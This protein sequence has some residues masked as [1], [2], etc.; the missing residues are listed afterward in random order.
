MKVR[1]RQ[2]NQ[3]PMMLGKPLLSQSESQ[4]DDF[5]VQLNLTGIIQSEPPAQKPISFIA[6]A[7]LVE[8]TG[9]LQERAG[10]LLG[11]GFKAYS[12]SRGKFL[13]ELADVAAV[14][15]Y[16]ITGLTEEEER[17]FEDRVDRKFSKLDKRV[18]SRHLF[19]QQINILLDK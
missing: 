15:D 16:I 13:E 12:E 11:Y 9:E 7:K 19:E 5:N 3:S 4:G 17:E 8:E 14:I 6:L 18:E 10:K 2:T 1:S